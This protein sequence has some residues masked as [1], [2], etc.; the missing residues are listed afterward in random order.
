MPLCGYD[1]EDSVYTVCDCPVLACKRYRTCGSRFL[2]PEYL[3]KVRVGGLLNVVASTGLG[4]V[5]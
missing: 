4:L 2:K 3:E 1:K 5:F